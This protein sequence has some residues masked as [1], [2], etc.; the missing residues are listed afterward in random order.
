[1]FSA[2]GG[3]CEPNCP[4]GPLSWA[5]PY[6]A[7]SGAKIATRMNT[8]VI[9]RPAISIPRCSPTLWR[10]WWTTGR[11]ER[12]ERFSAISVPHSRVDEG[13]DDVDDEVRQRHDDGEQGDH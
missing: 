1:M 11:R 10:S 6:G 8:P 4:S 13:R 7:M 2:L 12:S 3:R 5:N 9:T